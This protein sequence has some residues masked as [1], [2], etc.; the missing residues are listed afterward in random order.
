[1]LA[2]LR[3]EVLQERRQ[4]VAL[5]WRSELPDPFD[6]CQARV[7]RGLA[8]LRRDAHQRAGQCRHERR[9][10]RRVLERDRCSAND[11]VGPHL[12]TGHRPSAA[13]QHIDEQAIAVGSGQSTKRRQRRL[14]DVVVAIGGQ[15][16]QDR[17]VL[18]HCRRARGVHAYLPRLV[19][20]EG[21]HAHRRALTIAFGERDKGVHLALPRAERARRSRLRRQ[22]RRDQIVIAAGIAQR[23]QGRQDNVQALIAQSVEQGLA[24]VLLH[25]APRPGANRFQTHHVRPVGQTPADIGHTVRVGDRRS[26]ACQREHRQAPNFRILAHE[27][28]LER[29]GIDG[30]GSDQRRQ[31]VALLIGTPRV[32]CSRDDAKALDG[33]VVQRRDLAVQACERFEAASRAH[34]RFIL[35]ERKG[36]LEHTAEEGFRRL[37]RCNVL[38]LKPADGA[39]ERHQTSGL[40]RAEIHLACGEERACACLFLCGAGHAGKRCA[41]QA[42][43]NGCRSRAA[44]RFRSEERQQVG[45]DIAP[46]QAAQRQDGDVTCRAARRTQQNVEIGSRRRA[47]VLDRQDGRDGNRLRAA[48]SRL[49]GQ[50]HGHVNAGG[51]RHDGPEPGR[52]PH[53]G[54]FLRPEYSSIC[55]VRSIGYEILTSVTLPSLDVVAVSRGCT[56]PV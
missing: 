6:Q 42:K 39:C 37:E 14:G 12:F 1:M 38:V 44:R 50:R 17:G 51:Q 40:G 41:A 46:L 34:V 53:R 19:H 30:R 48:G 23:V 26:R 20:G 29:V 52:L 45:Y 3:I 35:D 36:L 21:E 7:A 54:Y 25:P 33:R 10:R 56:N 49:P 15:A 22:P 5:R 18:R 47:A 28:D 32:E 16:R 4:L 27:D 31:S 8:S 2:T 13:V 24:T 9:R 43:S 11:L 55:V